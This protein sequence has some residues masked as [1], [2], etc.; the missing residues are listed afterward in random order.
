[1]YPWGVDFDGN[2]QRDPAKDVAAA[3]VPVVHTPDVEEQFTIRVTEDG[4]ALTLRWDD[5]LVSVP[6]SH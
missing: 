5:V 6:L 4:S 2:A 3:Q 1:M